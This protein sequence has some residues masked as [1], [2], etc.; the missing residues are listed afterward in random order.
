[1]PSGPPGPTTLELSA[2]T[3][4]MIPL[5]PSPTWVLTQSRNTA[6][7]GNPPSPSNLPNVLALQVAQ[8]PPRGLT[9]AD[10]PPLPGELL[11][12]SSPVQAETRP[13]EPTVANVPP[14]PGEMWLA[15]SFV[16]GSSSFIA[17]SWRHGIRAFTLSPSAMPF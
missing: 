7:G 17:L 10:V 4:P 15:L 3:Q 2:T 9:L 6:L 8:P 13:Q 5:P 16:G 11:P 1:M 12:M 14:H